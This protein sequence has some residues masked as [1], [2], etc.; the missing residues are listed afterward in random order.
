MLTMEQ[1]G[2]ATTALFA[3]LYQVEF[4]LNN[5]LYNAA[6]HCGEIACLKGLQGAKGYPF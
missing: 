3:R 5:L 1:A 6:A 4:L 2:T